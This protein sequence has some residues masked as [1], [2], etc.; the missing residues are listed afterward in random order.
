MYTILFQNRSMNYFIL[1]HILCLTRFVGFAQQIMLADSITKNPV[2]YATVYDTN[3][4]VTGRSDM[5]GYIIL[6]KDCE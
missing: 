4:T 2:S 3:G 6:Q 1:A 5:G